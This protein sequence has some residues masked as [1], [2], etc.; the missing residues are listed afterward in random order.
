MGLPSLGRG[1]ISRVERRRLDCVAK[2]ELCPRVVY[3]VGGGVGSLVKCPV[4]SVCRVLSL[5]QK[6]KLSQGS[7]F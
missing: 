2:L 7:T 6:I 4:T 1:T 5:E 3:G